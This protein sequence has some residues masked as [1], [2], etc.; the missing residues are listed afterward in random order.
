MNM[1]QIPDGTR[2]GKEG[3]RQA[4]RYRY[5]NIAQMSGC[6]CGSGCCGNPATPEQ[7]AQ[8]LG[9]SAEDVLAV[10]E[11]AN[12]GLGCGNP[13]AI[14]DLKPGET[15]LDLGSG[16]GFDCF[17]AARQVGDEG[18]VIGVDMT[19]EMVA[20]A[21]DNAAVGNYLNVEFRLGEIENLPAAD[22]SVDCIMSNC[23]INLS[24]DKHRVFA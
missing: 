23:V 18:R 8:T 21:R 9:Y 7:A 11:G 20:K 12:M 2:E 14:A 3:I 10:P 22:N 13:R 15:V 1:A 16:G 19:P 24:P 4:V 6:G 5:G 17:L